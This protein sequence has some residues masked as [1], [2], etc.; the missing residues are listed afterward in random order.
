MGLSE[1]LVKVGLSK[2]GFYK[3]FQLNHTGKFLIMLCH[4]QPLYNRL[5]YAKFGILLSFA[6]L[7]GYIK[8][9]SQEQIVS[10]GLKIVAINYNNICNRLSLLNYV[11]H[12]EN[13]TRKYKLR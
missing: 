12:R 7:F 5:I 10:T 4:I 11:K 1:G 13:L 8:L 6:C 2:C 3:C 9:V